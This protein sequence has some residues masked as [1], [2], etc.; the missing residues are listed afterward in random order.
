MIK[1]LFFDHSLALGG[2]QLSLL[3]ILA[4]LNRSQYEICLMAPEGSGLAV[5]ARSLGIDILSLKLSSRLWAWRK[6]DLCQRPLGLLSVG[7]EAWRGVWHVAGLIEK[8]RPHILYTNSQK[9]HILGGLAGRWFRTPVIWHFRDI[10]GPGPLRGL[11]DFYGARLPTRI[12]AVSQAVARQFDNPR[13]KART[14]V[15]LNGLDLEA[16]RSQAREIPPQ[17]IRQ[18]LGIGPRTPLVGLVSRVSPGKGQHIFIQAAEMVSGAMPQARFLVVGRALFGE[19]SYQQQI[20]GQAVQS[21]LGHKV[22]FLEQ[23]ENPYPYIAA[24]DVMV[25]CAAEP[26]SFGRTVVEAMALGVPVAAVGLGAILELIEDGRTGLLSAPGDP[27]S[28]AENIRILA[29]QGDL[30]RHIVKRA[31]AKAESTYSVQQQMEKWE[32]VIEAVMAEEVR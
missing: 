21:G 12:I 11:A 16:V 2:A 1:I 22:F 10:L 7:A 14:V 8:W 28:L 18:R 5:R 25:H 6:E 24:L 26:E 20:R 4:H 29:G 17:R 27:A 13:S 31:R 30:R 9:A 3:D 15:I 19:E 23:Q 32:R